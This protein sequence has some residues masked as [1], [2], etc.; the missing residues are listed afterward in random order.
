MRV[1]PLHLIDPR[2]GLLR[3]TWFFN[4]GPQAGFRGQLSVVPG[5]Y[6]AR[7]DI[8]PQGPV[9]SLDQKDPPTRAGL[10]RPTKAKNTPGAGPRGQ[11]NRIA[12]KW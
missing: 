10:T 4:I 5:W 12:V 11:G 8:K 2:F 1:N 7:W 6:L 3:F 9:T